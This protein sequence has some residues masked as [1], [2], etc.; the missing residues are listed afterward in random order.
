MEQ[1]KPFKKLPITMNNSVSFKIVTIV[2]LILILLIPTPMIKS[3]IREREGRKKAVINEISSKWGHEQTITGPIISIPYRTNQ[4]DS[5]GRKI[6]ATSFI[7]ILPDDIVIA[8][9]ISP[10]PRHRGIYEV[11]LYNAKLELTGN[12]SCPQ[13]KGINIPPENILW[14]G[15]SISIGITDMRG[16]KDQIMATFND[17]SLSMSP[18]IESNDIICS[19]ISSKISLDEMNKKYPFKFIINLNG[20]HKIDFIPVGKTTTVKM[21]STWT[22][23]SFCGAYMP[24]KYTIREKEEKGFNAEWKILHLNRDYPQTWTGGRYRLQKSAFGVNLYIPV[25]IY[26]KSMRT[27]KYALLFIVLTFTAFFI[28][29]VMNKLRV[30]PIQYLLIGLAIIVFYSLLIS[31]SEHINF[32]IAYAVSSISIILLITGYAKSILKNT[33]LSAMVC[34]VLIALYSYMYILLQ[35]KDYT[36]SMGSIGLFVM[37]SIVMYMTRKIDWYAIKFEKKD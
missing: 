5:R 7:H 19:G 32:N 4:I 13:I 20:C 23:P 18:G 28:S 33:K 2:I 1:P 6:A 16:I 25:D 24:L 30:H 12:F 15:A 14:S 21:K 31:L 29:E 17:H 11:A 36:L 9:D 34:S 3:L 26:Q 22:N 10:V 37:L 27:T 35:L 8:S